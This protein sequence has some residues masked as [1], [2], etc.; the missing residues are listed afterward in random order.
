MSA[1]VLWGESKLAGALQPL[2]TVDDQPILTVDDQEITT[3][4]PDVVVADLLTVDGDPIETVDIAPIEVIIAD[5]VPPEYWQTADVSS[6]GGVPFEFLWETNPW[7]PTAQGGENVFAWLY[8]TFSWS[9]AATV[10]IRAKVDGSRDDVALPSGGVVRFV[11]AVFNLEQQSGT[12]QR[13]SRVFA[14]P[15]VRAVTNPDAVEI[16]R[17][18]LRGER[19]QFVVE[20]DGPLG[21]GELMLDGA[22]V[23]YD[24]VRKA[25]YA[26]G[27]TT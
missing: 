20:S 2:L 19:L 17:Y 1:N 16:S 10:R 14:V 9:M 23:D 24:P 15:L 6:D 21:V 22:Q 26:A 12:L 27:V 4:I 7:Q 13:V 8:L 3:L 18:Y 5:A 11:D 25:I